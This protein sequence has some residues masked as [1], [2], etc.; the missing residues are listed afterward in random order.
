[1]DDI[2]G[3]YLSVVLLWRKGV[4]NVVRQCENILCLSK[5]SL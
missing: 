4:K 5:K 1:M 2:Y 3:F